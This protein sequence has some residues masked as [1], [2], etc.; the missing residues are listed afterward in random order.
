MRD[1]LIKGGLNGATSKGWVT[2]NSTVNGTDLTELINGFKGI[3]LTKE[4]V[5]LYAGKDFTEYEPDFYTMC[6]KLF[7]DKLYFV[8]Y[9]LSLIVLG[10]H[11]FHAINSIFQTF[12]LNHRKYNKAIEYLAAGYAIIVPLGFAIVP[13]FVMFCK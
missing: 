10:L 7:K 6:N 1:A 13:L 5:A 2:N 11:L 8:I 3:T 9:L 4:E 12:G